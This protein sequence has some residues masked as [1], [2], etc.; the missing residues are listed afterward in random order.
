M[1]ASGAT[2]SPLY[3]ETQSAAFTSS[4][5]L[6]T[7][8]T[9]SFSAPRGKIERIEVSVGTAT[10]T[11]CLVTD[12]ES[13][14]FMTVTNA[15]AQTVVRPLFAETDFTGASISGQYVRPI[16]MTPVTAK[17][18][19]P[20]AYT[21]ALNPNAL[22]FSGGGESLFPNGTLAQSGVDYVSGNQI[23]TFVAASNRWDARSLT[24]TTYATNSVV[25]TNAANNTRLLILSGSG[26]AYLPNGNYAFAT[27]SYSTF[28][29]TNGSALVRFVNATGRWEATCAAA[30]N[31]CFY[32]TNFPSKWVA[33]GTETN[34]PPNCAY[35]TTTTYATNKVVSA[36]YHPY[37]VCASNAFPT[38]WTA[39]TGETNTPPSGAYGVST[40]GI[41]NIFTVKIV[42]EQ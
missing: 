42:A 34:T 15:V 18:I 9:L 27:N 16:G 28:V 8:N 1:I 21:T 3:Q 5:T 12:A 33:I 31:S 14:T 30:S 7:T 26:A 11:A 13:H 41:S 25:S 24:Y 39:A 32:S 23:V 19:S 29:S 37:F 40:N 20:A 17:F 36:V 38:T 35:A 22:I 10:N 2:A 6:V 4:P